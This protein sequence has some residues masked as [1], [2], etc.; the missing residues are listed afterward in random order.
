MS[1][2]NDAQI[3]AEAKQQEIQEYIDKGLC[4][5]E[6]AKRLSYLDMQAKQSK[7]MKDEIEKVLN[8]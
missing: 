5:P 8:L 3:M 4:T 2:P 1:R 7:F 6:E